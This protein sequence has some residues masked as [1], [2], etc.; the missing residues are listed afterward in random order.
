LA[1]ARDERR[2]SV[3]IVGH[4]CEHH[5]VFS[6]IIDGQE[7]RTC[8]GCRDLVLTF[9][10]SQNGAATAV[11]ARLIAGA[12]KAPD[13][14]RA[15][16]GGGRLGR[17]LVL[18]DDDI[19][20]CALMACLRNEGGFDVV[21]TSD[22]GQTQ[23]AM[24]SHRADLLLLDRMVPSGD[25]LQLVRRL[26]AGGDMIPIVI[27]TA[28]DSLEDRLMGFEADVDDYI[29]KPFHTSELV[30]RVGRALRRSQNAETEQSYDDGL[31]SVDFQAAK[32]T[33]DG[34]I[35][36]LAPREFQFLACLVRQAGAIRSRAAIAAGMGLAADT[37]VLDVIASRLR[38]KLRTTVLGDAV[39]SIRSRGYMYQPPPR[40]NGPQVLRG[41]GYGHA[42]NALAILNAR[43]RQ[44]PSA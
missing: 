41:S 36:T 25:A 18:E 44:E 43:E 28:K 34:A 7:M 3:V 1:A 32:V 33:V 9:L 14:R 26:R 35:F 8:A 31:L 5:A 21:G 2:C 24:E 19:L 38:R 4:S 30:A 17:V 20:R 12:R 39:V 13:D 22:L 40:T 16:A 23:E 29:V 10:T 37:N 6:L 27:V 42:G 11:D 15:R